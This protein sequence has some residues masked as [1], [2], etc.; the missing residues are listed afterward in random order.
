MRDRVNTAVKFREEWRPFAPSVTRERA[1][2]FFEGADDSPF[3]ILTFNVRPEHRSR[4]AGITHVDNT[5]RVQ[6]VEKE[7]NPHYWEL[8]DAFGASTGVPIVMNT[9]F[10]LRGEPI[11]CAPTDA[12]RTFFS[13]GMDALILGDR[14]IE[15]QPVAD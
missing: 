7:V 1:A 5:A 11:V 4:L 6:T 9:S 15:K 13:S 2:D 12:I 3:M 8:I 14:L 10:N